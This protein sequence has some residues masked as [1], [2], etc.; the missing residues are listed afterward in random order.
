MAKVSEKN[1]NESDALT[2]L[3][4]EVANWKKVERGQKSRF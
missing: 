3:K 2:E 4:R 1:S